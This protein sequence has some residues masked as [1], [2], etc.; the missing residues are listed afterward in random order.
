MVEEE[1]K[2]LQVIDELDYYILKLKIINENKKEKIKFG[3]KGIKEVDKEN[4]KY[5]NLIQN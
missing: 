5:S 4:K 2:K 1:L 3:I